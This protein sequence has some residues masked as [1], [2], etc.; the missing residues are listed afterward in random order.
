MTGFG[1]KSGLPELPD[2][3]GRQICA[4]VD[5][6]LFFADSAGVEAARAKDLAG[7]CASCPVK[8]LCLEYAVEHAVEGIWAGTTTAQRRA[9]RRR[10]KKTLN[11]QQ[12]R[13]RENRA[14][15]HALAEKGLTARQIVDQTGI[16]E[17]TV[18]RALRAHRGRP[19]RSAA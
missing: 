7:L 10:A 1:A 4:K 11:E 15:V 17:Q 18:W 12:R 5:P 2:F 6:E 19:E 16:H 3:G 14:T 9:M 13:S 8:D